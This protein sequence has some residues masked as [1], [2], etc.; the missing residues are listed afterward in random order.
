MRTSLGLR[1]LGTLLLAVAGVKLLDWAF[2]ELNARKVVLPQFD[3]RLDSDPRSAR[4]ETAGQRPE[5]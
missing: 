4:H 3:V 2:V 1:V 5:I